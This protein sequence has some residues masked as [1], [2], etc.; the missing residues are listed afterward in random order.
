MPIPIDGNPI[1]AYA[2]PGDV[3]FVDRNNDGVIN[4]DD[5][6]NIGD[7]NPDYYYGF[8]FQLNYKAFDLSVYTYGAGGN[9]ICLWCSRLLKTFL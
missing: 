3:N 1:Q 9:Q 8:N 7:P 5:K 4:A 6:T 2:Q